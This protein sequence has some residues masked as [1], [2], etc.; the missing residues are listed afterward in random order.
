MIFAFDLFHL[1]CYSIGTNFRAY[2]FSEFSWTNIF[3]NSPARLSSSA[4]Y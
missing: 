3:D 1:M 2:M 4:L